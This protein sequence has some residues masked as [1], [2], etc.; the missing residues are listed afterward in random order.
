MNKI[1]LGIPI[2]A[3]LFIGETPNAD[4]TDSLSINNIE[5]L[6]TN[7]TSDSV[8]CISNGAGCFKNYRWYPSEREEIKND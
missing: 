1:I 3:L 5:A 4:I 2:L 6:A 8:D 7:E